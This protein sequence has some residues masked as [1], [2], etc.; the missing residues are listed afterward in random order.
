MALI[1]LLLSAGWSEPLLVAHTTLLKSHA[2]AQYVREPDNVK[3]TFIIK[4]N[5]HSQMHTSAG[6]SMSLF[7]SHR[8][9]K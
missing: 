8:A 6:S 2:A 7:Y 1:R 9:S 5:T 4:T 3:M